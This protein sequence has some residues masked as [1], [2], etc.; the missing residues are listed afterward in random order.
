MTSQDDIPT[1]AEVARLLK[2][3]DK[4]VYSLSQKGDL[5]SPACPR[6]SAVSYST[7]RWSLWSN[8]SCIIE[9]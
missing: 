9:G 4:T 7:T 6:N 3:A 2:V 5:A 1:I 8:G